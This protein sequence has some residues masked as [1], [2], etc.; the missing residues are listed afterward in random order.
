MIDTDMKILIIDDSE[1]SHLLLTTIL[2][3]AGFTKVITSK[4]YATGRK[5]MEDLQDEG[6]TIDLVLMDVSM[7][8]VDGIEAVKL[9]KADR[10]LRDIPIIMVTALDDEKSLVKAF[11]AG[12]V[13]YIRKP[14]NKTELKARVRSI[15]RL[16]KE[17]E[18]RKDRERE[19]RRLNNKL[20]ELSNR[21]GLTGVANRRWF[22]TTIVSEWRRS[23]RECQPLAVLVIDIDFFKRYNDSL[24]HLEGD[25]CLRKVADNIAAS[26]RRPADFLARFGGEEFI[27]ILPNTDSSGAEQVA[28]LIRT[29]MEKASIKHP[30]SD[31]C[32][33]VTVSV[34]A[35]SMTPR[36]RTDSTMLV[37]EADKA[38]YQAKKDGRNVVVVADISGD[39]ESCGVHSNRDE[40]T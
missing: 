3:K 2:A 12:A 17:M 6:D 37:D 27:V 18:K 40:S 15:L 1:T 19:L 5:I 9:L 8:D 32:S 25:N 31:V 20:E 24:G 39:E 28:E 23:M 4:S 35:A 16:R 21:D 7:P 26:L 33:H 29:N 14:V 13:D 34:G 22:D 11:E 38:L 30:D 10:G 36:E